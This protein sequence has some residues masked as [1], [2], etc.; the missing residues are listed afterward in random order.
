[1]HPV[2]LVPRAQKN[3]AVKIADIRRYAGRNVLFLGW[4]ITSKTIPSQTGEAMQFV[5]FE[6]ETGLVETVVFPEA[7]KKFVRFLAWQE[8]FWVK[9]RVQIEYGTVNVLVSSVEPAREEERL[10]AGGLRE[11]C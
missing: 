1:V 11:F 7:Y 5:T 4:C 6:D 8:A 3:G 9:G 2:T 10:E